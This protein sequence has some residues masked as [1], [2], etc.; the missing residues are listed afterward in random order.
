MF[1]DIQFGTVCLLPEYINIKI[2]KTIISV[3][4]WGYETW[5]LTLREEY[6]LRVLV[7]R[8]EVAEE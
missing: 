5:S 7:N 8:Q 2:Y 6:I 4:L 3:I 1:A